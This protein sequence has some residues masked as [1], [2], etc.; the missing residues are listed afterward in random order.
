MKGT[1]GSQESHNM[2]WRLPF[3][4]ELGKRGN[5]SVYPLAS[6]EGSP[7]DQGLSPHKLGET[8][9]SDLVKQWGVLEG[10]GPEA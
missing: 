9:I 7:V 2:C 8:S 5:A 4:L 6:R 3:F 1:T 10:A